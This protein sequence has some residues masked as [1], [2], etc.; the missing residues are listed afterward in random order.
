MSDLA[1]D[2]V[3]IMSCLDWNVSEKLSVISGSLM[4][5]VNV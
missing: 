4:S 3:S 1:N 2:F 5:L